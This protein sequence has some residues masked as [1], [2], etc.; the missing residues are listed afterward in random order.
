MNHSRTAKGLTLICAL[1]GAHASITAKETPAGWYQSGS[2]AIAERRERLEANEARNIILF[3]GDGMSIATIAAARI[4]AGQKAGGRGEEYRLSFEDFPHIALARTYNTDQQTPDSAGTM[5]AMATGVKTFVGAIG[6]DQHAVRNDCD[7]MA[8]TERVSL[9]ELASASGMATGVV[10]T[11]R[12]THAT[13]AAVYAKTPERSWE[14]DSGMPPSARK[15]GCRD[16]ARQLVEYDING[17]IDIVLGGGRAAFLP[18]DLDDPEYPGRKGQRGDGLN[19][20]EHWKQRHPDGHWAWNRKGFDAI[21]PGHAGPV[22]G[23]FEP[24]HMQYEHDRPQDPAGEPSIAEM[25]IKALEVLERRSEHGY[26]LMVEG[27]RIDHAHHVGNAYR[28]L[29]DTIAFAQA[30]AATLERVNLDETMIVVTADHGHAMYFAGYGQR[31]NPILGLT[32]GTGPAGGEPRMAR[33]VD[34]KPYTTLGY[35]NGP[36]YRPGPRP[37]YEDIDP[38]DPD[39]QQ[40][41]LVGLSSS[42]HSGEDVAVYS[43]GPGAEAL[44]GSIEQH[45]IFHALLQA[46]PRLAAMADEIRGDD[47]LP[48]WRKLLE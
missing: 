36:G 33:D 17:P 2:Q 44:Y 14:A 48:D 40:E 9:T 5:T 47:G 1:C 11:T 41:A 45:L 29:T 26:M 8:G 42:T 15:A 34:G 7:S 24:S 43:V 4:L 12:I 19:L 39:F 10:T 31:G 46:Q 27:G 37:D 3:V 30:V 25:T 28:A 32:R 20:I 22:L 18:N 23:L 38:E 13:P 6:V 21:D 16:I 35:I